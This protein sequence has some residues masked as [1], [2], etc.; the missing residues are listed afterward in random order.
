MVFATPRSNYI[1]DINNNGAA[2]S[3]I[4]YTTQ[5]SVASVGNFLTGRKTIE[6]DCTGGCIKLAEV[7]I[8]NMLV[9]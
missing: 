1:I 8:P 9:V 6:G 7:C 2:L 5:Q 3:M 4:A